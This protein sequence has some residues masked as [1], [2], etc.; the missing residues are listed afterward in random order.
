MYKRTNRAD[1]TAILKG[2]SITFFVHLL[3]FIYFIPTRAKS[4]FILLHYDEPKEYRN[5]DAIYPK[6]DKRMRTNVGK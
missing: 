3:P 1:T 4:K 2:N 5:H 6:R